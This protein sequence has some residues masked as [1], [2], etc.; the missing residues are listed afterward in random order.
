[1]VVHYAGE[2][3]TY[4][5]VLYFAAMNRTTLA[6]AVVALLCVGSGFV[7]YNLKRCPCENVEGVGEATARLAVERLN[8]AD[9]YADSLLKELRKP[10]KPIYLRVH[11]RAKHWAAAPD[12]SL[13][14]ILDWGVRSE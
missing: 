13:L 7:G 4:M 9:A 5:N 1:M 11:E 2:A 12:D 8:D 3:M 10:G 6:V 14:L